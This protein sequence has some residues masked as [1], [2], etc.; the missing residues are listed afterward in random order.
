MMRPRMGLEGSRR[1]SQHRRTDA[2]RILA[3][4]ENGADAP[5]L[6]V[7]LFAVVAVTAT[8]LLAL[9]GVHAEPLA[10]QTAARYIVPRSR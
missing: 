1:A 3:V 2:G 8:G 6:S 7:R 10:D 9:R 4:L 5:F